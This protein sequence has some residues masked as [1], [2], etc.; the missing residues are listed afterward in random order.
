MR[1][2][3]VLSMASV[4][5]MFACG[6]SSAP[7]TFKQP[8][9]TVAVNFSVDDTA[10]KAYTQP[11]KGPSDLQWKG[12][13]L[14]DPATNK[15]SMDA[16]WGGPF[17]ALYDDGPWTSGGHEPEGST[18]GDHIFGVTVFV[19]PPAAGAA[20]DTYAYGLQDGSIVAGPVV[21]NPNG[22]IWKGDNGSFTVA[23]G[24]TAAIK[25]DGL[26]LKQFG[27][28]DVQY[29]VNTAAVTGTYDTSVMTIK[30][31]GWGWSEVKIPATKTTAMSQFVGA[32]NPI[33]HAGLLSTGDKPEFIVVFN[34]KE[35]R[36]A[37]GA[38]NLAGVSVGI[39][40]A[41]ASTYSPTTVTLAG[42]KNCTFTVP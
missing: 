27:T 32:G 14:Y 2:L 25:A 8:A 21:A 28:T 24:A 26:T 33:A 42:N 29:T 13:M 37:N 5:A 1:I 35:Y 7:P 38:C 9:G 22:W 16:T 6:G 19:T 11:A 40:A 41:G 15:V 23:P 34:G 4:T 3:S 20:A 31:S 10:N 18:A 36:D 39:K 12:A 30:S 17:A